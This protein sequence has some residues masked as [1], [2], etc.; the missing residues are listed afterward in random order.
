MKKTGV[1]WAHV[2]AC[3]LMVGIW[4][5]VNV[6]EGKPFLRVESWLEWAVLLGA[7][8][9]LPMLFLLFLLCYLGCF[10]TERPPGMFLLAVAGIYL[11]I[12][13]TLLLVLRWFLG[14]RKAER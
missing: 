8:I 4:G 3:Y 12:V 1:L 2:L 5:L 7:P 14:R 9:S 6:V 10:P 13:L 11:G